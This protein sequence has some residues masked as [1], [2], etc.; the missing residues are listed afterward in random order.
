MISIHDYEDAA[1][2]RGDQN[3]RRLASIVHWKRY[4][5]IPDPQPLAAE[6]ADD[7]RQRSAALMEDIE[8]Q[9]AIVADSDE[10]VYRL[11]KE[12]EASRASERELKKALC[13]VLP[14]VL[15]RPC[16]KC[17]AQPGERCKGP[18]GGPGYTPNRSHQARF[19][20]R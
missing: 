19:E 2:M 18:G 11:E 12:L 13:R 3:R 8:R 16:P 14:L 1:T 10:Y 17:G 20:E 15:H 7:R 6:L 5:S 9:R 4:L